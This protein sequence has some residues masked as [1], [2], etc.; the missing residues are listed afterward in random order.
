[1][2]KKITFIINSLDGGGTEKHL[3][4]LI[5]F[6]QNNY[7]I[8]IFAF[9]SGR[10]EKLFRKENILVVIPKKNM[11]SFLVLLNFLFKNTTDIYHFFLPKS[12]II[13]GLMTFFTSKKKIM[14][15]RSL[16]N[17]HKKYF[18]ISLYIEKLLHKRMDLILTNSCPVKLQLINEGV[19][20]RKII[21]IKNFFTVQRTEVKLRKIF[22]LS[23]SQIIFAIVANLIPYKNHLDLI[24]ACADLKSRNWKLLFIG[25]DRNNY[26]SK[27][28]KAIR[29]H[30]LQKNII[31]TGFL[32]DIEYCL[33]EL[34]F[35]VNFS[36]EEGSS[37]TL[38]QAI[39]SGI[40][41]VASNIKSN[42]QFVKHTKNGFL[43]ANGNIFHL[44]KYLGLML[45]NKNRVRMG[46][47]SKEIY[48]NNFDY[49][50]SIKG[51]QDVYKKLSN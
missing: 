51:Y 3:L 38:L 16:N 45:K 13:G 35:I 17:Y 4:Q 39:A 50:K 27:L 8:N 11:N 34:D 18:N 7:K 9:K 23:D 43:V 2:K 33:N 1:M 48:N 12:Y 49:K 26:K 24:K 44:T 19:E 37:N 15:R 14:S 10:L 5:R 6:L 31:F 29:E 40:P 20:K 21:V 32:D 47:K 28:Q 41:I 25:E 22:G 46:M 42:L 30:Q 36:S